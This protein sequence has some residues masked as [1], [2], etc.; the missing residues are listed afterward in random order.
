MESLKILQLVAVWLTA[1]YKIISLLHLQPSPTLSAPF[2]FL[3]YWEHQLSQTSLR[4][5]ISLV[6]LT[7]YLGQTADFFFLSQYFLFVLIVDFTLLKSGLSCD[8]GMNKTN[9]TF[10]SYRNNF[11]YYLYIYLTK[12]EWMLFYH[13]HSVC[14]QEAMILP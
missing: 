9:I 8:L 11:A 13:A 14:L 5:L 1:S 6:T 2:G 10:C 12:T 4:C 7:V 3:S